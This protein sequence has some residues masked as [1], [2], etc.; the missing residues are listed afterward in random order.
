MKELRARKIIQGY[1]RRIL[2]IGDV[3]KSIDAGANSSAENIWLWEDSQIRPV[4]HITEEQVDS[5]LFSPDDHTLHG[6]G[7]YLELFHH[8]LDVNGQIA[9]IP[10]VGGLAAVTETEWDDF[11][12]QYGWMVYYS[13]LL[14][15]G[16]STTPVPGIVTVH[17]GYNPVI[18]ARA[19]LELGRPWHAITLLDG[20]PEQFVTKNGNVELLALLSMEKQRYYLKWQELFKGQLP[21]HT[22][23][24]NERSEFGQVTA[25]YPDLSESYRLHSRFW[26]RLNRNDMAIRVL[27]SVEHVSPDPMTRHVLR[28]LEQ[29]EQPLGGCLTCI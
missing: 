15:T 28:I 24:T 19:Q 26:S 2:V 29:N 20:I 25:I 7:K 5:V 9:I 6:V 22:F 21:D 18:H 23:F 1:F 12:L 16:D 4:K 17:I 10:D 27:Q 13:G 11:L 14:N 8:I 3:F